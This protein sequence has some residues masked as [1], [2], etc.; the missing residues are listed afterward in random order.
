MVPEI[1]IPEKDSFIIPAPQDLPAESP[2]RNDEMNFELTEEQLLIQAAAHDFAQE[3]I[4]PVAA[5]FD[6]SGEFPSD[7]IAGMGE[8]GLMGIEVPEQ[9][10]G[11]GLDAVGYSLALIEISAADASHATIMS[12]NNSLYCHGILRYGDE[13]QPGGEEVRS[14][15]PRL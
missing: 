11:A 6:L 10:G 15:A 12:V 2:P 5:E 14:P 9:Y 1:L 4:A 13:D 7:T 3:Q 8:L